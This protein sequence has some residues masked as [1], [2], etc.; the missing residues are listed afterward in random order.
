VELL[1][2]GTYKAKMLDYGVKKTSSGEAQVTIV[3]EVENRRLYWNGNLSGKSLQWTF[4]AL[5]TCGIRRHSDLIHLAEGKASNKLDMNKLYEVQVTYKPAENGYEASNQISF[6][7]DPNV[8]RFKNAM[9]IQDFASY[10]NSRN[11]V[12]E[13]LAHQQNKE[14]HLDRTPF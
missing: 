10:V 12:A 1:K 8:S 6:I 3:F 2:A 14:P 5:M 7:N 9:T 4:D 11:L 13:F